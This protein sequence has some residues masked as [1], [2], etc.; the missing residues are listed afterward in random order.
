MTLHFPD[1][2]LATLAFN[3]VSRAPERYLEMRLD[4]EKASL[5]LSLGGV[6][7]AS[8]SINRYENRV[9]PTVRLS[10]VKGGEARAEVGAQSTVIAKEP[11]SAFASATAAHLREILVAIRQPTITHERA[12]HAREILR[13]IFAGYESNRRHT[14][15]NVSEITS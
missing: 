3:R 4:C 14:T 5:R 2:R 6:A 15:V 13:T 12:Y 8:V 10:Y 7:R 11:K 1:E 9:Q